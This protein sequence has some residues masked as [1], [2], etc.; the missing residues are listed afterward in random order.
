MSLPI[1]LLGGLFP[2]HINIL[3][4]LVK[5]FKWRFFCL[6]KLYFI[7]KKWGLFWPFDQ[8][9]LIFNLK[10]IGGPFLQRIHLI[11]DWVWSLFSRGLLN[12]NTQWGKCEFQWGVAQ[13]T[14][15]EIRTKYQRNWTFLIVIAGNGS[16]GHGRWP[17]SFQF[18]YGSSFHV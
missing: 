4:V 12:S 9:I 3:D 15:C 11:G 14:V 7:L 16:N 13:W 6:K 1:V 5:K 10:G 18:L 17:P 8:N 2:F